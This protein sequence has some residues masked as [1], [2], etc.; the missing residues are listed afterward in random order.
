[1]NTWVL[2]VFLTNVYGGGSF[3]IDNLPDRLECERVGMIARQIEGTRVAKC[4]EV[5]RSKA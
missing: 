2:V 3:G 1:M 5:R 4:I